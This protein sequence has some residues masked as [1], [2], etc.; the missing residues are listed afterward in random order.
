MPLQLQRDARSTRRRRG[1]AGVEVEDDRGRARRAPRRARAAR[2]ARSRRGSRAR[3]A[4][5][6]SS[7]SDVVDRLAPRWRRV[8]VRTHSG[9]CAGDCFW[10]NDLP[11]TPSGQ[12]VTVSARAVR[13]GRAAPARRRRSTRS[14]R[15]CVKPASRIE[16]LVE[17]REL[18][19]A[20]ADRRVAGSR[21]CRAIAERGGRGRSRPAGPS[22]A[23][24]EP[25]SAAPVAWSSRTTSRRGLVLA[26]ALVGGL[27]QAAR[28]ASTRANSTSAT[29]R[30]STEDAPRAAAR[31]P[32]ANGEL[33]PQRRQQLARRV[34]LGVAEAGA[35]APDVAQRAVG[36]S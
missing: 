25:R 22:R 12:R 35:D 15:A 27:A 23:P 31:S 36:G 10:K 21:R 6:R 33:A 24:P 5:R 26:Q 34:E 18:Q 13:G 17:V 7:A 20:P 4:S 30:G 16:H 32:A 28:G 8:A 1:R 29:S 19:L 2:A 9:R 11:S 14:R 3:R